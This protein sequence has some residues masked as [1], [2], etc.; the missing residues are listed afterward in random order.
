VRVAKWPH[1]AFIANIEKAKALA[2]TQQYVNEFLDDP[3]VLER[4][5]AKLASLVSDVLGFDFIKDIIE[6]AQSQAVAAASERFAN[7]PIAV[8]DEKAA[9]LLPIAMKLMEPVSAVATLRGQTLLE[10]A[11]VLGVTAYETYV[12]D[13]VG[14]LL[15][16]NA[17]LMDRFTDELDG[18]L[19]YSKIRR[20]GRDSKE[21]ATRVIVDKYPALDSGKVKGL[22]DRLVK[23]KNVFGTEARE[24]SIRKFIE[25]RHLI[26][27][28]AG[29]IDRKFREKTGSKLG[30]G[31][32]VE[33]TTTFVMGGL[34]ELSSFAGELQRM[35]EAEAQEGL[36]AEPPGDSPE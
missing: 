3:Q 28:R 2:R 33:L 13:T 29:K 5:M 8:S 22:F 11:V 32:T 36:E 25:H 1:E 4:H 15:R 30:L 12:T 21:A 16:L 27:H 10:Q 26:V 18:S 20:H 14:V 23:N 31:T 35:L 34:S 24:T 19:T 9:R 7:A 17:T 6:P